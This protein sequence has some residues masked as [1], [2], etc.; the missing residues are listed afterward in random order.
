MKKAEYI[1]L[2]ITDNE[3][4][5]DKKAIYNDVI[6]CVDIA[7]SQTPNDFE[8][9]GSIGLET[10]FAEIEKKAKENQKNNIGCVGPFEAAELIA[11]KLGTKYERITRKAAQ[12]NGIV[13]LEDFF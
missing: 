7:L 3:T 2:L 12:N 1:Q 11:A 13:N 10:L 4:S 6:D 5:G 9:D 8:L